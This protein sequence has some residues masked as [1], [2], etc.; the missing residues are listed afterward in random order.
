MSIFKIIHRFASDLREEGLPL[1]PD[2]LVQCYRALQLVDWDVEE[3]YYA[4]LY[5]TLVKDH[6][7]DEIF[8]KVYSR[9]FRGMM[10]EKL[11]HFA[12]G[13]DPDREAVLALGDAGGSGAGAENS[14]AEGLE[15]SER[16]RAGSKIS[17]KT[18]MQ[19]RPRWLPRELLDKHFV[20]LTSEELSA[21]E[22]LLPVV[23]KRLVSRMIKK[24]TKQLS[25]TINYRRTFRQSLSTG[26]IP[27]DLF[28]CRRVREKPVI[29]A[30]CDVS[31]SVW[32]FSYFSLAL[33][34]SLERFFRRVR[35]FA[36]VDELDE[37]TSLLRREKPY[38]L[39]GT[40][41]H[42]AR[43]VQEGRTNYGNSLK[44]FWDRYGK[45]LSPQ[46]YLLIF[47]DARNNW[48]VGEEEILAKISGKVKRV[49]WF[50]P[51]D[52]KSW[53]TGD[54]IIYKYEQH[55][56]RVYS[57]PNLGELEQAISSL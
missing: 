34:H 20:S 45:D 52:K 11:E 32:E 19:T 54:S 21:L 55:C 39:R 9:H 7:Y 6:L 10:P 53:N 50:N 48:H 18:L 46:S 14:D 16:V 40:V 38:A 29:F 23:A 44:S 37:I 42:H 30:L 51:E 26:G 12:S 1:S 17:G 25:G 3:V 28:T 22:Q 35:S 49:Y 24:R 15:E 43:V 56:H 36:F 4:T 33:V 8:K 27:L 41:L 31:T 2:E 57:C 5:A 47:G 13:E